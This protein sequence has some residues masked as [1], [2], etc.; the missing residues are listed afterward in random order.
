MD[1]HGKV[2]ACLSDYIVRIFLQIQFEE[3]AGPSSFFKFS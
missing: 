1:R 2:F 3:K